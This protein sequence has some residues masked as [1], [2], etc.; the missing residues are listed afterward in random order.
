[1]LDGTTAVAGSKL[2]FRINGVAVIAAGTGKTNAGNI[3]IRDAGAGTT[4][5]YISIGRSVAEVGVF[6]VPA[7]HTLVAQGWMVASRDA[8]GNSSADIE[9][10]A[11]KNGVRSITWASIVT[12]MLTADF[13]L[14]H[15][16]GE[17]T[18]IEV[19]VPRVLNSNTIVSF[20]GHGLLVSSNADV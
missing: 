5:S 4:R 10:W 12:G 20:H 6:T 9:F 15:V 7:G 1:V 2:F 13:T 14:P 17:K 3:T 18:D 8:T 19:I 11:T 16:W